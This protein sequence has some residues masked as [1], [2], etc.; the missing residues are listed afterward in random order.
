MS[1]VGSIDVSIYNHRDFLQR[2]YKLVYTGS[3]WLI[4][5]N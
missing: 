4:G 5:F 2:I 1:D 3:K